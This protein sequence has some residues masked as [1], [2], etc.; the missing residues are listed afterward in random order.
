L[1]KNIWVM[2]KSARVDLLLRVFHVL[3]DAGRLKVSLG[4]KRATA[5]EKM[6]V[7]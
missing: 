2:A 7:S 3:F 6:P 5:M 1:S 4:M